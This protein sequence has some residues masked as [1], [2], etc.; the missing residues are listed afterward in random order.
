M[1]NIEAWQR[2]DALQTDTSTEGHAYGT[3]PKTITATGRKQEFLSLAT[4]KK[5]F[6]FFQQRESKIWLLDTI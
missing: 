6:K 2:K 4:M 1:Y 5:N 3:L